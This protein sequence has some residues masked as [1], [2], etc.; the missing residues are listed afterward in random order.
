M[1][2]PQP[3]QQLNTASVTMSSDGKSGAVTVNF[4]VPTSGKQTVVASIDQLQAA[5]QAQVAR[6]ELVLPALE[7]DTEGDG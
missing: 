7:L 3:V 2:N 6:D 4:G 1:F 5:V